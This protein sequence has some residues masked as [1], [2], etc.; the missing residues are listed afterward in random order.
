MC[1]AHV[2]DP[3]GRIAGAH[4]LRASDAQQVPRDGAHGVR[5]HVELDARLLHAV[6]GHRAGDRAVV[7]QRQQLRRQ[8]PPRAP[9]SGVRAQ[10][11]LRVRAPRR[12][13]R[14]RRQRQ[15]SLPRTRRFAER[16]L[17]RLSTSGCRREHLP[18]QLPFQS[19]LSVPRLFCRSSVRIVAFRSGFKSPFSAIL[20][21]FVHY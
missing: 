5:G 6:G 17:T 18:Q 10:L 4:P 11:V 15:A 16:L 14:R 7:R 2:R 20:F 1:A 12:A 8:Q 3:C 13:R 9:L 19:S 21:R